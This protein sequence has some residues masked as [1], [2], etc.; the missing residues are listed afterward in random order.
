[1][2]SN[3]TNPAFHITF[4]PKYETLFQAKEKTIPT[5]GIR[6]SNLFEQSN[7]DPEVSTF[8]CEAPPWT[9]TPATVDLSLHTDVKANTDPIIYHTLFTGVLLAHDKFAALYTDGSKTQDDVGS[10]FVHGGISTAFHLPK[11]AS[12]FTAESFAILKA[13]DYIGS[14][15][16]HKSL[17]LFFSA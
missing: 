6:T 9:L 11:D 8:R 13:L 2:R 12:I 1:M 5:F 16:L 10:A 4:H 3:P 7:I 17:Y 14:K 15:S